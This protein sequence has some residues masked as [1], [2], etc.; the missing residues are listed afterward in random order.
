MLL[1]G[2]GMKTQKPHTVRREAL[3]LD[4][5]LVYVRSL[6]PVAYLP[7]QIHGRHGW[8]DVQGYR[9]NPPNPL[10]LKPMLL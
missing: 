9:L 10:T 6:L 7:W 4:T 5:S 1:K 8:T 3:C 2:V